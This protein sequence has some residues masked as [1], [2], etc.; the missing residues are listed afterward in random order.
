MRAWMPIREIL[1][2]VEEELAIRSWP[3]PYRS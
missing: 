1:D 3:A 2:L